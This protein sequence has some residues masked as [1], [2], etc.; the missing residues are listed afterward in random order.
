MRHLISTLRRRLLRERELQLQR[1]L[2]D[3]EATREYALVAPYGGR[4]ADVGVHAGE[5][6]RGGRALLSLL[7]DDSVLQAE[8]FVPS[9]AAG[10][11]QPGQHLRLV[12]DA[13]P[14]ESFGNTPAVVNRVAEFVT[15]PGE[16]PPAVPQRNATYRV[17]ATLNATALPLRAGMTLGAELVLEERSMLE[18]LLQPLRGG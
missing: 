8:I 9:K 1:E 5:T 13:F 4:V 17:T 7:P 6:V 10:R 15:L 11:L 12:F 3:V 18:W 2:A 16:A 14:R